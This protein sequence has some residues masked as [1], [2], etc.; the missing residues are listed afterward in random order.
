MK[1]NN[2]L[3]RPDFL[4][5]LDSSPAIELMDLLDE[6][7]E[8]NDPIIRIAL[9]EEARELDPENLDVLGQLL[10]LK[11]EP[12]EAYEQLVKIANQYLKKH[13]K[14]LHKSGYYDLENRPYFRL[15][16]YLMSYAKDNLMFKDAEMHARDLLRYDP[17]DHLG[18]RFELMAIYAKTYNYQ[19]AR[20]FFKS[21][22]LY[23]R[24]DQMLFHMITLSILEREYEYAQTLIEELY[25]LNPEVV[26][27]FVS[28]T[29]DIFK[30]ESHL[31]YAYHGYRPNTVDSL[32]LAIHEAITAYLYS[33]QLYHFFRETLFELDPTYFVKNRKKLVKYSDLYTLYNFEEEPIF[34]G[35]G[36]Q[37][38]RILVQHGLQSYEDFTEITRKDVLDL[39]GI[40]SKTVNRLEKNGVVFK[41]ED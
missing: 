15:K 10:P 4:K 28:D 41:K 11:E 30:L 32:A 25:Q 1:N 29:F 38:I 37:Y 31:E 40:G 36:I 26:E 18:M 3:N 5:I 17:N 23:R 7:Q 33:P 8:T 12:D 16:A 13:R 14:D 6:V 27:L 20:L 22:P 9:L 24:Q 21:D 35:I 39:P 19:K 34:Q 2:K